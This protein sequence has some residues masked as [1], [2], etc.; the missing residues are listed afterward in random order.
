MAAKS[1][2]LFDRNLRRRAETDEQF[3]RFL[4]LLIN[5]DDK[6]VLAVEDFITTLTDHIDGLGIVGAV[7]LLMKMSEWLARQPMPTQEKELV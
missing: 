3:E 2:L 1:I 4:N 7:E 6:E 5:M